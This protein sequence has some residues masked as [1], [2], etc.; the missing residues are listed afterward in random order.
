RAMDHAAQIIIG[1]LIQGSVFAVVALGISLVFRVS[2][3]INLAQ[4]GFCIVGALLLYTAEATLGWPVPLAVLLAVLGTTAFGLALGAA[5]FVPALARLP[6]SSML[7]LTAGLLTVI[8]GVALV[9]WG[10]QPYAVPPFSGERPI[11]LLGARIPSQGLWIAAI[12]T[13]VILGTWY[14]LARTASGRA[15]VAC[16]EN[17]AAARV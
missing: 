1:G 17:P 5:T 16:A 4:G 13:A 6:N 8:E 15:L 3:I 2:G 7:M 12:A 10:T 11:A 14:L 9:L